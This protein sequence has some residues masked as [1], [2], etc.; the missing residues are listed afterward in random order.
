MPV[1]VNIVYAVFAFIF[2]SII[3]SFLNVVILR[4]PLR[5]SIVTEPSHCFSCGH[6]LAWYDMFPIFSWLARQMSL[7][8]GEDFFALHDR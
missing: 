1:V 2:G 4:T 7:L 3:G 6:R 5:Q 8:Q